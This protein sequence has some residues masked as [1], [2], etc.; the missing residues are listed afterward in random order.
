[1]PE[2]E[3]TRLQAVHRFLTLK[4]SK[5]KELQEIVSLAAEICQTPIALITLLDKD[6][7]YIKFSVGID[8]DKTASE[9]TFCSYV[10]QQDDVMIVPDI[11][12]DERFSDSP[13]VSKKSNIRFYAGSPLTTRNGDNVGCLCVIG[14]EV[15]QLSSIQVRMLKL[16]SAQVMQIME[17]DFSLNILKEQ[18]IQA[19]SAEIKLR[20]FFDSS[21]SFHL[22]IG[23]EFEVIH[24][25]K[26]IADYIYAIYKIQLVQGMKII[27]YLEPDYIQDFIKNYKHALTGFPVSTERQIKFGETEIW[28][29]LTYDPDKNREGEIIG[30]SFNATDISERK[31]TEEKILLQNESLKKIAYIQ[32]HELR[33]PV[34]SIIGF[35]NI[36][37]E[38]GYIATKEDLMMMEKAVNDLDQKIR[39]I[40]NYAG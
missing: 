6:I 1:M 12:Q 32:S 9:D 3:L 34:A 13:L 30:V 11:A 17:F 27:E 35:M 29:N 20:S 19:K 26:S 23:K 38:D 4:I 40:I 5:G 10:I 2:N 36:F 16:L 18:F 39:T 31:V 25:N 22:F 33:K 15:K 21:S 28:F 24:F 8:L 7:Q 37:K 14:Y